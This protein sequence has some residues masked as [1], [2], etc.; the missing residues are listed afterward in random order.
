[1]TKEKILVQ[2][3]VVK[4]LLQEDKSLRDSDSRL[5]LAILDKLGYNTSE[6]IAHFFLQNSDYP[7]YDSISRA[8]RKVQMLNPELKGSEKVRVVRKLNEVEYRAYSVSDN[9]KSIF[10]K[11]ASVFRK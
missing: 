6:S 1:M 5:Y 3:E 10:S 2:E 9:G 11:I 7:S 8:R 4:K